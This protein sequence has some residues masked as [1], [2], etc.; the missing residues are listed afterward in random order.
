MALEDRYGLPLS[1]TS[2]EAAS[3]YREGVD[4][5]LAGWTG[6]AE[7]L[8]RGSR[9]IRTSHWRT[10]PVPASM[11]S[12]SR[13]I[14]HGRRRRRARVR[15]Q[16]RH[17]A[18]A[19]A[20]RDVGARDRGP[21]ARSDC[22]D[23]K[24]IEAGRAMPWCCRC[25]SAR[26]ACSPSPAWPITTARGMS[27]ASASRSITA[28]TGGFSPCM[29]GHDREWRRRP[30]PVC[31]RARFRPAAANAHA[32]HAVLH[33]MFE[34]GSIEAADR[35][36]DEWLPS[37]GRAG[38]LHGHILWH[39][40]L[41]ALDMA[42]PRV[43]SRS[44]PTCSNPRPRRRRRSTSSPTVPRCSGGCRPTA[45]PCRRR[46]GLMPT[47]P[48]KNCFRNRACRLPTFTWRCSRRPRRTARRSPRG[49]P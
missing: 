37:Y 22:G 16:A 18:R 27:C 46:S 32:A 10:S 13:A 36:V 41:G 44:M 24:H 21:L 4:L 35:L 17:R 14:S 7:T 28:R 29:A 26:S 19:L 45:M 33:A 25:R 15:C 5:M 42:M 3:A 30:R 6:T 39:Q 47:P 38:I 23:A 8:E 9:P 11:P 2:H 49:L 43:R 48:R 40:A 34:D 1:T 20:C 31:H 12:T